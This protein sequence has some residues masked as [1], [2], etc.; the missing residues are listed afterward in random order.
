M[1]CLGKRN[2]AENLPLKYLE[3]LGKL[4]NKKIF[5]MY[6]NKVKQILSTHPSLEM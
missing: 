1:G 5:K 3:R 2:E 4:N 6:K